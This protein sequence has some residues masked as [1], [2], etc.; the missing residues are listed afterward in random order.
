[1]IERKNLIFR[2]IEYPEYQVD[3]SGKIYSMR[4]DKEMSPTI[5]KDGRK[6]FQI[7]INKQV[8][9]ITVHHAVAQTFIPNPNEYTEINHIDGNP[10]NNDVM[11]LEW[12]TRS[13]NIQHAIRNM[14]HRTSKGKRQIYCYPID[15]PDDIRYFDS[16]AQAIRLTGVNASSIRKCLSGY[17]NTAGELNGKR[18]IWRDSK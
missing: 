11:N 18:L 14:L 16:V 17:F 3:T 2:G 6:H 15:N 10:S 13:E 5:R 7:S 9:T 4:Y 8:T 12:C 1:M